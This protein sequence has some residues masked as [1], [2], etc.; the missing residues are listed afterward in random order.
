M[1]YM[2]TQNRTA[3]IAL[4]CAG[5]LWGLTVPLS[6]LSLG[7]LGP[8]WLT[9][10]R[11]GLAAPILAI[12]GRRGLRDALS[13]RV[14]GLG[15]L[16][17]GAVVLLQNAGLE[18]TSVSHAAVLVGAVPV[19]AA[20]MSAGLGDAIGGPL[21]WGGYA[22]ALAGVAL[23]AG[24]GGGGA[25][26]PGDL[27]V[28]ASAALSAV[29]VVL[30][31]RVLRDRDA[32][33]VTAVQFAAAAA[34]ALPV[35]ALGHGLPSAPPGAVPVLA[36]LALAAVGTMLPFWLFAYGQSRV[37]VQIAGAYLNLEPVVGAG[38]GWLAFGDVA[39]F[40]QVAGMAAVLLGIAL[41][42]LAN[43]ER[44]TVSSGPA[45]ADPFPTTAEFP[46]I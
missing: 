38:L 16:G 9:V 14:A 27:L 19:L 31:P 34:V 41:S 22:I 11:F 43:R 33:A 44:S 46:A 15:A 6:K 8:G 36:V 37:P 28:L 21:S 18:R 30:Q 13:W 12:A 39:G 35:A 3:I 45:F 20:L 5:A 32:T 29:F 40:G 1:D 2:N 24:G 7:W 10:A 23:V 4:A 25:T 26:I 17:F 42:T